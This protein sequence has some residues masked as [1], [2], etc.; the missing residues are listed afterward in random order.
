MAIDRLHTDP[1]SPYNYHHELESLFYV[2]C[3]LGTLYAG[4]RDKPRSFSK[5]T[6]AY[7]KAEVAGWNSDTPGQDTMQ[8]IWRSKTASTASFD[9][10]QNIFKQFS[11]YFRNIEDCFDRLDKLLFHAKIGS[12]TEGEKRKVE[13][14]AKLEKCKPSDRTSLVEDFNDIPIYMRPPDIVLDFFILAFSEMEDNLPEDETDLEEEAKRPE[15]IEESEESESEEEPEDGYY[16]NITPRRVHFRD[17]WRDPH[18]EI[19]PQNIH[20]PV[21]SDYPEIVPRRVRYLDYI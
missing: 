2:L 9:S 4:P 3:W 13:L 19:L 5:S 14:E 7:C 20:P 16:P 11:R 1:R 15:N 6:F 17:D 10:C 8:R 21:G 12:P 18:F